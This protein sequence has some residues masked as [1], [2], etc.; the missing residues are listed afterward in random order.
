MNYATVKKTRKKGRVVEVRTVLVAGS[1]ETLAGVLNASPCSGTVNTSFVERYN[2]SARHFNARKQRKTY[3]FSKQSEEHEAMSWLMVTHYNFCWQPR[4][5]RLPLGD[6]RYRHRTPA[7][8]A[9][10][11]DHSWSVMELLCFQLMV[12]G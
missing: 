5:L 11:T 7:M 2:G 12:S 8:A 9:G 4:T 1:E 6:R 10:L 3:S